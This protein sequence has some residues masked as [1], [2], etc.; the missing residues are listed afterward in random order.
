MIYPND[1]LGMLTI[2]FLYIY[3]D[4]HEGRG[5]HNKVLAKLYR[6][7]FIR[8]ESWN[9]FLGGTGF[10]ESHE[11]TGRRS[12]IFF[13]HQQMVARGGGGVWGNFAE[14]HIEAG[15]EESRATSPSS[16]GT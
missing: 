1:F 10:P 16:F 8:F 5:T 11:E 4:D 15:R 2:S 14:Y 13:L 6:K 7:N 9:N 3:S 12:G